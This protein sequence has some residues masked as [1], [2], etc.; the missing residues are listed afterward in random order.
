MAHK[1]D[2]HLMISPIHIAVEDAAS[3]LLKRF[4]DYKES[5]SKI[6][7]WLLHGPTL[8]LPDQVQLAVREHR[9]PMVRILRLR[10]ADSPNQAPNLEVF[11]EF[12]DP[13][14]ACDTKQVKSIAWLFDAISNFLDGPAKDVPMPVILVTG[15]GKKQ[16][17]QLILQFSNT[18]FMSAN[19][20]F[21]RYRHTDQ[22]QMVFCCN[23]NDVGA[24]D[25]GDNEVCFSNTFAPWTVDSKIREL[26]TYHLAIIED[27]PKNI[28]IQLPN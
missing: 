19:T 18:D 26:E 10:Y 7:Q 16:D 24:G 25:V 21:E 14:Y 8:D 6:K 9:K 17:G 4:P 2:V 12:I 13:L 5:K 15:K 3:D 11:T 28:N 23:N 1:C 22:L 27:G 20:I